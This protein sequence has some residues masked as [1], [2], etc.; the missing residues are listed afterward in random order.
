MTSQPIPAREQPY[1]DQVVSLTNEM[2]RV[3]SAKEAVNL[4]L[5]ILAKIAAVDPVV[6]TLVREGLLKLIASLPDG[7]E[8]TH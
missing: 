4:H 5:N 7:L 3:I 1:Y 8:R 6:A 2:A